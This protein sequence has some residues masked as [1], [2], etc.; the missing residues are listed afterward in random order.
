MAV[1]WPLYGVMMLMAPGGTPD[2]SSHLTS[3]VAASASTPLHADSPAT[4]RPSALL[5]KSQKNCCGRKPERMIQ[6]VRGQ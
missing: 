4:G 6:Q 3:A 5:G 2:S 1:F